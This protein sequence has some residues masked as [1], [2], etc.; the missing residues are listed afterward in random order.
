MMERRSRVN[1]MCD[2]Y[3]GVTCNCLVVGCRYMD[4]SHI[5]TLS[6]IW[7][8]NQHPKYLEISFMKLALQRACELIRECA[9]ICLSAC[10]NL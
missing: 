7:C 4:G 8:Y 1:N 5:G 6:T 2:I 10:P 9:R 3:R